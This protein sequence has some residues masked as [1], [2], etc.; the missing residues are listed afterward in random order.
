MSTGPQFGTPRE[1]CE[2]RD[3]P[4]VFGL[5]ERQGRLAFVRITLADGTPPF[6]DLPGGAIDP[7]ETPEA[8]LV[9]EFAEETGLAVAAA[10]QIGKASQY[11]VTSKDEAVNNRCAF[12]IVRQ[13][14]DRAEKIEDDHELIWLEPLEAVRL[15]RHEAHAWGVTAWI[16]SGLPQA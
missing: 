12:M 5:L 15:L 4:A 13:S 6:I 10:G 14:G 3:R 8:A 1:G 7:G 11:F 16:R 9:R 2:H